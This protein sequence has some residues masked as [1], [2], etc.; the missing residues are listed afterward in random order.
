MKNFFKTAIYVLMASAAFV[1]C[2]DDDEDNGPSVTTDPAAQVQGTYT[3]TLSVALK[4]DTTRVPGTMVVTK[5]SNYLGTI[6][7][8]GHEKIDGCIDTVNIQPGVDGALIFAAG[9][10]SSA[11]NAETG[12]YEFVNNRHA[13]ETFSFVVDNNGETSFSFKRTEQ[14]SAVK[15]NEYKIFFEGS[16][17]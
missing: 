12:K 15:K 5:L 10:N 9:M 14:A 17:N 8:S 7:I 1:A 13:T 2:D 4:K 6:E 11:K 16:K 3:G